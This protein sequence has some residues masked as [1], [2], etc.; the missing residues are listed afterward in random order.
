MKVHYL[1]IVKR[2]VKTLE[3]ID[4]AAVKVAYSPTQTQFKVDAN[5]NIPANGSHYAVRV[6]TH[7]VEA[8]YL[9]QCAPKLDPLAYL[10]ARGD[11]LG[12]P[13]PL[14]RKH[15]HLL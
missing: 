4:Y 14:G 8:D 5:Y 7:E 12:R 11:R 9:Y 1:A 2:N 13:E 6:S 10:T 15:E 3:V